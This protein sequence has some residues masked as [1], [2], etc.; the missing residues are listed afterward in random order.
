MKRSL[1]AAAALT[2]MAGQAIA[3]EEFTAKLAGHAILPA[4]S[5]L[6]APADAPADLNVSGKFTG[7]KRVDA[8]GSVMGKSAGRPTGL[9]TPFQGQPVQGHSGIKVMQDGSFWL[10][11]DN[12]FGAKANSPDVML[13]LNRYTVDWNAGSFARQETIFLSDPNKVVPFRIANEAT[14]TRYLTGSDFDTEG[15]QPIGDSIWIGDEFGPWLIEID[16]TGKVKSV[17]DTLV[18]G[19]VA[20]SPDNPAVQTPAAPNAKMPE[21]TIRRSKGYE[22]LA[23]APDGSRLYGL[24]E[25]PVWN[26][27]KAAF[28]TGADGKEV[29]RILEFDVAKKEWTGRFWHYPLEANGLAIGDFNMIS[30]T[31]GLIIERDNGEG[32]PDKACPEGQRREDCFHDLPKFKRIYKFELSDANVGGPVRKIGY[33]D[34]LNIQDPDNKARKPKVNGVLSFPFFTI[35]N[36][37]KVDDRH[38]VVG[39]DNNLPFSSSREPNKADDNELIL[40]DVADFLAAK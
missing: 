7:A 28:E 18:D 9:S 17:H 38:I 31:Q 1:L 15:F 12:G 33:I 39:N 5:F 10:L 29:L 26:A 4:E 30:P 35:E 27:E 34:L 22:G 3:A 2:V 21:F 16:R 37:D 8:I 19:K 32:T 11:T 24:L 6:P 36:V 23:A 14:D 13:F 25:G 20:R 40:L